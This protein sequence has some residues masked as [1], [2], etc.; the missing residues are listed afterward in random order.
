MLIPIQPQAVDKFFNNNGIA[1]RFSQAE[2]RRLTDSQ[3]GPRD[4][5]VS[6]PTPSDSEQLS[7]L[8]LRRCLG[9]EPGPPGCVF[10]DHPWYLDEPF[11]HEPCRAGWHTIAASP[12]SDSFDKPIYYADTLAAAGL[13]LPTAV[14]VVLMLFLSLSIG[15]ERLLLRKHTWTRTRTKGRRFVSVGAFGEKGLFVSSHE[16]GYQSRGLGICPVLGRD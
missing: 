12:L 16:V 5:F 6:Y 3:P 15:E 9:V 8:G 4:G 1:A 11:G 7:I 14:E 2:I 10:F 13:F